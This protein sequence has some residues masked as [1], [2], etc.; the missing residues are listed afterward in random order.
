MARLM[1]LEAA[2]VGATMPMTGAES[3][4]SE[5]A[6]RSPA[7]TPGRGDGPADPAAQAVRVI[8]AST[9][10]F[11]RS[12]W[13]RVSA[14]TSRAWFI[15]GFT[16]VLAILI[17]AAIWVSQPHPDATLQRTAGEVDNRI[18]PM[19]S[20]NIDV[21]DVS[22][23]RQFEQY[24]DLNVWSVETS[25]GN[26]CLLALNDAG[27]GRFQFQCDPPGIEL[28]LHMGVVAEP[29]DGFGEWLP[30]GS[31]ISLHLRESTVEVFVHPPPAT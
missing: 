5:A 22:T 23:L 24:H 11:G 15:V 4:E 1:E 13:Q 27:M 8:P 28:V 12:L 16:A 10:S 20:G 21:R 29:D 7:A 26:N 30:A 2:H 18:I 3:V 6:D 14:A 9:G 31:V 19:L 17:H 25:V